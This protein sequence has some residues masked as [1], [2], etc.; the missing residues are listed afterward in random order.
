[1]IRYQNKDLSLSYLFLFS[2][3]FF[4]VSF[5][6]S[7]RFI[8]EKKRYYY[9]KRKEEREKKMNKQKTVREGSNRIVELDED[10]ERR[11]V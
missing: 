7:Y 9:F 4:L 11:N 6:F 10:R 5:H 1:M 8:L 2:H 3:I